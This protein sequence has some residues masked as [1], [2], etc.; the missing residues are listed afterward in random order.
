VRFAQELPD[1]PAFAPREA[2]PGRGSNGGYG[3][4][5][6]LPQGVDWRV[7]MPERAADPRPVSRA[8]TRPHRNAPEVR[9]A[10]A[11]PVFGVRF[12]PLGASFSTTFSSG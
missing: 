7:R 8:G 11:V 9:G 12:Q 2:L 10:L 4:T 6:T 5:V 1:E 3:M